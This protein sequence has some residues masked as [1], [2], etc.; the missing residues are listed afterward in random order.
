MANYFFL[1]Q[2]KEDFTGIYNY[3]EMD[4]ASLDVLDQLPHCMI[5]EIYV[6]RHIGPCSR[7]S[8]NS[9]AEPTFM[10]P[11]QSY[12]LRKLSF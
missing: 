10:T 9:A 11:I 3:P 1:V 12:L 5:E 2:Y 7:S 6:Q 4:W 8:I